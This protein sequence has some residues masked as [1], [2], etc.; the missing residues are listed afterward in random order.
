MGMEPYAVEVDEMRR[1]RRLR[2]WMGGG[3]VVLIGLG[4]AAILHLHGG[5]PAVAD[6]PNPT[7]YSLR[8]PSGWHAPDPAGR[9]P[10]LPSGYGAVAPAAVDANLLLVGPH[11]AQLRAEAFPA[12]ENVGFGWPSTYTTV[13]KG[14]VD[15]HFAG[16]TV[17]ARSYDIVSGP[18]EGE[19][20]TTR[21]VDVTASH[22]L[23]GVVQTFHGVCWPGTDD[24][25]VCTDLLDS[26]RWEGA[27]QPAG[28]RGGRVYR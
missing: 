1:P 15:V 23:N 13:P 21:E 5:S 7:G 25:G 8:V 28:V 26:W 24:S 9:Y 17:P 27:R 20:P 18:A 14:S 4:G 2:P 19:G 10:W 16:Q 22:R 11:G 3:L 12:S 6:E